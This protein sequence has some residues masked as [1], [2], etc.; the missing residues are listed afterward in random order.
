MANKTIRKQILVGSRFGMLT[1]L[2]E[3]DSRFV[4]DKRNG[5]EI[6]IRRARCKCDCGKIVD[7]DYDTLPKQVKRGQ[8]SNCGCLMFK[9][10]EITKDI[11]SIPNFKTLTRK[12]KREII[13]DLINKE[14]TNKEILL[15]TGCSSGY[16]STIRSEIGKLTFRIKYEIKIGE[17]HNK[18]TVIKLL[19]STSKSRM[20]LGQCE[21]GNIKEFKYTHIRDGSTKSCGCL[22]TQMARD[23]MKN[24]LVVNNIKHG[25]VKRSSPHRY[26]YEVWL[27][28]KQ[29]CYNPKNK[30]YSTYG[31]RGITVY[32]PWINDYTLFKEWVLTN[33]GERQVG[34]TG[35]R[36]DDESFDRINVD[37]GYQPGNLRWADFTT[38]VNNKSNSKREL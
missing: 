4:I 23:M 21:C 12:E 1:V 14:Y 32:E 10:K 5:Y 6:R 15:K 33:L 19:P 27:G 36:G 17:V 35:R 8:T 11:T 20:V 13:I 28:M 18:I 31:A 25:D 16:I 26:L 29:R 2:N 22:L 7:R 37:V 34:G 24:T 3:T 30:R 9:K 38:Q